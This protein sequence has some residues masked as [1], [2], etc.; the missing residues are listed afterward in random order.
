[1]FFRGK[2]VLGRLAAQT[3]GGDCVFFTG[4]AVLGSLAAQTCYRVQTVCLSR[5]EQSWVDLQLRHV[6]GCR[7]CFSRVCQSWVDFQFKDMLQGADCMFFTGR[8]VLCRFAAQTCYRV[9]TVCFSEGTRETAVAQPARSVLRQATGN[10]RGGHLQHH[11][12][13]ILPLLAGQVRLPFPQGECSCTF[14]CS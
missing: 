9:G 13:Q 2:S 7:L 4:R 3:Q 5:V 1:M 8:I 10:G 14:L 11:H 12:G 6:T